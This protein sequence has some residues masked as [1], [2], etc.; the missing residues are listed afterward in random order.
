MGKIDW[1]TSRRPRLPTFSPPSPFAYSCLFIPSLDLRHLLCREYQA[2]RGSG[3]TVGRDTG[4]AAPRG[5][6]AITPH[7]ASPPE[8]E[9]TMNVKRRLFSLSFAASSCG[10]PSDRQTNMKTRIYLGVP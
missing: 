5:S 10:V 4:T 1:V 8:T 3:R 6:D 9:P 2:Q 7:L